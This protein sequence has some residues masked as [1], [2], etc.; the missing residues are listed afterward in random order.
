MREILFRGKRVDGRGWVEGFYTLTSFGVGFSPSII[1][2]NGGST[3]PAMVIPSTVGQ[4]TG[5][6]DKNGKN[7]FEGDRISF[8]TY[9]LGHKVGDE[10]AVVVFKDGSFCVEYEN[11]FHALGDFSEPLKESGHYVCNYGMVYDKYVSTFVVIG[12]IHQQAKEQ[13]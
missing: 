9:I 10:E 4:F 12:N 1:V 11:A 7:S 13:S 5:L 2:F 6:T 8:P 3:M